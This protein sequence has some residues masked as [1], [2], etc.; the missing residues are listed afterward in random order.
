[1]CCCF[2][3]RLT[4]FFKACVVPV[5][6]EESNKTGSFSVGG[7]ANPNRYFICNNSSV[8]Q[9]H[10]RPNLLFFLFF[11][12]EDFLIPEISPIA[13]WYGQ[14]TWSPVLIASGIQNGSQYRSAPKA[15]ANKE[16]SST[17]GLSYPQYNNNIYTIY[18]TLI[19]TSIGSIIQLARTF[20]LKRDWI[21]F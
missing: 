17:E 18:N 15:R 3:R 5:I 21:Q 9:G 20:F 19:I 11:C 2:M 16:L 8:A 12:Q 1:M 13:K 6:R 7:S 10:P 4:R 14:I